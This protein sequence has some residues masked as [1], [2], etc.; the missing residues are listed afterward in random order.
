MPLSGTVPTP[1]RPNKNK[2]LVALAVFLL[3]VIIAVV[4][5]MQRQ[6]TAEACSYQ[7]AAWDPSLND[8][9]WLVGA[10][11]GIIAP[12]GA[13]GDGVWYLGKSSL[14]KDSNDY[15]VGDVYQITET[16]GAGNQDSPIFLPTELYGV[17]ATGS[18]CPSTFKPTT[19]PTKALKFHDTPVC[20]DFSGTSSNFS[21]YDATDGACKIFDDPN[22]SD[23]KLVLDPSAP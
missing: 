11:P 3:F 18:S 17:K 5:Y 20:W 4:V 2:K 14:V 7:W 22:Y 13:G 9:S 6:K 16:S 15:G 10:K 23:Y 1:P 8:G 19:D 12:V 21:R